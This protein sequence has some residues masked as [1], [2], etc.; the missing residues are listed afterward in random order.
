VTRLAQAVERLERAVTRLEAAAL[1]P[2]PPAE[3]PPR[4]SPL[5]GEIGMRVETAL[6][7]IDQLIGEEA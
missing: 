5:V 2:T 6:A 1:A 3:G 4:P 7:R